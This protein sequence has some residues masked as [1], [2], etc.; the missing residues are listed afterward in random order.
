VKSLAQRALDSGPVLGHTR[1]RDLLSAIR[2]ELKRA[3]DDG[4]LEVAQ[5]DIFRF[6]NLIEPPDEMKN[7][8]KGMAVAIA[9]GTKDFKRR[10]GS[11]Q[12][13]R[14]DGAWF[15][16]SLTVG[17][18]EGAPLELIAYSF[19]LVFPKG[20]SP[21]FVRFDL[22]QPGHPN[23]GREIR[24]HMH[25]GNEDLQLPSPVLDP[26]ESVQLMLDLPVSGRRRKARGR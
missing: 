4:R 25:P 11:K 17:E 26:L 23:E 9:G 15:N 14:R 7:A 10:R 18:I 13:V 21:K 12:L 3:F 1:A 24:S 5:H 6:V 22:N 20:H 16:F 8:T 19:E 2:A